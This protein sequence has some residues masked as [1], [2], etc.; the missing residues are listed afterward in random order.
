MLQLNVYE[1]IPHLLNPVI[2]DMKQAANG[3]RWCVQQM[4]KRYRMMSELGVRNIQSYNKTISENGQ[5]GKKLKLD[6]NEEEEIS[7]HEK[8]PY[9]VDYPKATNRQSSR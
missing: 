5:I 2:T 8:L 7:Y 1:G 6:G 4:E 9:I 3:L